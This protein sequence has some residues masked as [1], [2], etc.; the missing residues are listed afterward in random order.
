M[1]GCWERD[2]AVNAADGCGEGACGRDAQ[3]VMYDCLVCR[4]ACL[5]ALR[6]NPAAKEAGANLSKAAAL[7]LSMDDGPRHHKVL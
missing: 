6:S 2:A 7:A 3:E 5:A 1:E 4:A